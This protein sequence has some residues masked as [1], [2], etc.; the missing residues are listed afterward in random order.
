MTRESHAEQRKNTK[1]ADTDKSGA[2]RRL[3]DELRPKVMVAASSLQK[4]S[5]LSR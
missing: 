2:V 1:E 3:N 5:R 4:G